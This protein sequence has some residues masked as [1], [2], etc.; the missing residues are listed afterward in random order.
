MK[1][2]RLASLIFITYLERYFR[3]LSGNIR[4]FFKLRNLFIF[5]SLLIILFL[6]IKFFLPAFNQPTISEGFVGVYTKNNLPSTVTN[7]LS[8]SLVEI[9]RKGMPQ[10]KIAEKWEVNNNSTIYI[11]KV[12]NNLY[13]NDGTKLKSSDIKFNLP[14]VE[15]SYPDDL[16]IKFKLADSFSPFP[17]F[18][19]TPV[20]KNN[21]LIGLGEYILTSEGKNKDFITKMD[22]SPKNSNQ[23]LP[24]VSIKFYSDEKTAR[25]AFELG[26][27]DSLIGVAEVASYKETPN[28]AVKQIQVFNK[29]VAI[30][31]NTKDNI[32]S[33]KNFRRA[34]G[35]SAPEIKGEE[36]AKTSIPSSSWAF[37][38]TV[39]DYLGDIEMA[40]SYFDKVEKGKTDTLTLTT[41]PIFSALGEAIIKSWQ[42]L[43]VNA[44]LR[45]ESG[46]PQNFQ[47]LLIQIPIPQDPDQY[48]L[49]HSTQ[50]NTNISKYSSPRIDKDLEDGRKTGDIE[51]RKE[52][53][54]DF[55]K[56]LL[57]DAP[58]TFLYFPKFNV[59]YRKK[60]ENNIN[61]VIN[62]QIPQ[63]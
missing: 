14:D 30:V 24:R 38:D 19:T 37:N 11:F 62:L 35:F 23:S 9:D 50:T 17:S 46:I 39:K 48:P 4:S 21:S 27:I 52:K 44:V 20:F 1:K 13:W 58:A 7:L 15:I 32:L 34:L 56:I 16:T 33:D 29:I 40:K 6:L 41:T 18:L 49:W 2:L 60:I 12:K 42:E 43:G 47:A 55:Q 63:N 59:I 3:K 57:D 26:E 10:P 28:V 25:T 31:Y 51:V 8:N 45:I 5:L 22:L 53:Y 54:A 61:K 36:R